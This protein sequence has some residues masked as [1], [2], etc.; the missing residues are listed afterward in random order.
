MLVIRPLVLF[1]T[2]MHVIVLSHVCV[3]VCMCVDVCVC[4]YIHRNGACV[5]I[6][7]A[8]H[9]CIYTGIVGDGFF[10]NRVL[11]YLLVFTFLYFYLLLCLL[12]C[13]L[14]V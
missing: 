3:C 10:N 7:G 11:F 13:I 12:F 8:V 1:N 5:D 4:V 2:C 6:S 9:V 14:F